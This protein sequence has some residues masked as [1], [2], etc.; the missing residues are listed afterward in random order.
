MRGGVP[1]EPLQVENVG[2][3]ATFLKW[4]VPETISEKGPISYRRI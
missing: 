4:S 1:D 3:G 2:R